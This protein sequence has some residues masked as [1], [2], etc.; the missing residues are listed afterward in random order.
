MRKVVF[1]AII[2]SAIALCGTAVP[3]GADRSNNVVTLEIGDDPSQTAVPGSPVSQGA[4]LSS[5]S[6]ARKL[7]ELAYELVHAEDVDADE[8]AQAIVFL[9]AARALDAQADYVLPELIE[10]VCRDARNDRSAL[11]RELLVEYASES[12]DLRI[13]ATAVKY[14]LERLNSR[15]QRERLVGELL[16]TAGNKNRVLGSYL[17]TELGLLLA[18]RPD[19]ESAGFYLARAYRVNRYNKFAFEKLAELFPE[20]LGPEYYVEHLRYALREDPSNLDV[21]LRLGRYAEQLELYETAMDAYEYCAKLFEYLY[22]DTPLPASIYLPWAISSYNAEGKESK[23]LELADMVRGAGR[24]DLLLEALAG[25]AAA[26]LGDGERATQIFQAAEQNA[27]RLLAKGPQPGTEPESEQGQPEVTAT[28]LA[29]FYCFAL[30]NPQ[31][32]LD[33]ANKAYATEPNAASTGG[34]LAY[35]LLMNN[36]AAWA[37][38]LIE[39]IQP[40]QISELVQAKIQLAEGNK[41]GALKRLKSTIARDP[42]SLAA[43]EAKAIL[44]EQ[45]EEYRPAVDADALLGLLGRV[46]GEKLIPPFVPPH[47]RF[48]VQFNI[49]GTKFAYG[50][51]FGGVIAV[52]NKSSEPLV[53]TDDGLL[54]GNV[55]I[56]AEVSGDLTAKIPQLVTMKVR[57]HYLIEPG[58]SI[59]IPVK[60]VTGKL[61]RILLTCP[62]ASLD[63][64][65]TLY[66]DPVV[67]PDGRVGNRLARLEPTKLRVR[68]QGIEL[69]AKYLRNRFN[70]ISQ[71]QQSQKIKTAQLFIGL[72]ME[73]HAMSNRKPPY[74]L[75]YADWMW[76]MFRNALLHESG[77]L[78][79]PGEGEWVVKVH[80]MAE[81]IYLPMDPELVSAVAENLSSDNWPVRMMA[82]YLLARTQQ[83][84]FHKVLDWAA[85]YDPDQLVREMAEALGGV[86]R[87][88]PEPESPPAHSGTGKSPEPGAGKDEG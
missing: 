62:Q 84:R 75:V 17:A 39:K 58:K 34:I 35:A 76:N 59:L 70:L 28:Q 67:T 55:R 20:R 53:I 54:R 85:T 49:R 64:E 31:K 83:G 66:M 52:V 6:V 30:P 41:S 29:W 37:K 27:R 78:R 79:N 56:D 50:G 61:R 77:L 45:G 81:M 68:R 69:S 71:G 51:E 15:E 10:T 73:Q 1:L 46:F 65:Y 82:M 72:L 44:A 25:K 40:T 36:Q 24:F 32:A 88:P 23:C 5:P 60:L 4:R 11:V 48:S 7:Y 21:A 38:P 13:A 42:G 12:A 19:L 57:N 3:A 16:L 33:W 87:K 18:E 26:K 86:G 9:K 22:P 43:E 2:L 63:I 8:I 80:T 47:E 14:L 74:R